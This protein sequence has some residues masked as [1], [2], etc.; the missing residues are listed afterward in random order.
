M[1]G[2]NINCYKDLQA[3]YRQ[4]VPIWFNGRKL[5]IRAIWEKG[6][7]CRDDTITDEAEA[8]I[9]IEGPEALRQICLTDPQAAA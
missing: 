1:T 5:R 3:F 9:P 7:V 8:I 2:N 6:I 4:K